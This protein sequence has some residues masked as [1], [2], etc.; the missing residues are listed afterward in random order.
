MFNEILLQVQVV[1]STATED[2]F[3]ADESNTSPEKEARLR[4]TKAYIAAC[5]STGSCD[6]GCAKAPLPQREECPE[7]DG[8]TGPKR[9]RSAQI[10]ELVEQLRRGEI[11]KTELFTK[12]QQLQGPTS[13]GERGRISHPEQQHQ[14]FA[15]YGSEQAVPVSPEDTAQ[16]TSVEGETA[17][18]AVFFTTHDRQVG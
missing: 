18:P 11:N 2:R 9:G 16:M 3:M 14:S 13:R 17:H 8:R 1:S 12:L 4:A 6:P 7:K 5:S 10:Y 15:E